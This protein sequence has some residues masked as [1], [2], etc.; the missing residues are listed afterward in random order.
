MYREKLLGVMAISLTFFV[1]M[2][3]ALASCAAVACVLA[4][5]SRIS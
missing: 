1:A 2:N 3:R 5:H 4:T